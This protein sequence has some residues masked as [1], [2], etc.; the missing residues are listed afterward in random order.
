VVAWHLWLVRIEQDRENPVA[1]TF[2]RTRGL[3]WMSMSS[4]A[5]ARPNTICVEGI[6]KHQ[7]KWSVDAAS[8][9]ARAESLRSISSLATTNNRYFAV[10]YSHSQCNRAYNI[11]YRYPFGDNNRRGTCLSD[12]R[13][14][15][16]AVT[17]AGGFST[18][19]V[20]RAWDYTRITAIPRSL[21]PP[22]FGGYIFSFCQRE[23]NH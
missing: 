9:A 12:I 11:P 22:Q 21:V 2:S 14:L 4:F 15:D 18:L 10:V 17:D 3:T 1:L 8:A 6:S 5:C 20:S 7:E 13:D 23:E 19:F 16:L